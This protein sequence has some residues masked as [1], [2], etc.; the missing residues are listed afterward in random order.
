MAQNTFPRGDCEC[1]GCAY[2][3][4]EF[5]CENDHGAES[6]I[7]D[8][9][10]EARA[11]PRCSHCPAELTDRLSIERGICKTCEDTLLGRKETVTP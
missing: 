4:H 11:F 2:C 7:C 5:T 3:T 1:A 8:Q 10:R 9:C 6:R